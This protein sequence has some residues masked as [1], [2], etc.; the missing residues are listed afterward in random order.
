MV[1]RQQIPEMTASAETAAK[2]IINGGTLWAGGRQKDFIAEACGRAGGLM[3]IKPLDDENAVKKNDVVLYAVPET[4]RKEDIK[5]IQDWAGRGVY[6]LTFAC[7]ENELGSNIILGDLKSSAGLTV[8]DH[9]KCKMCPVDTISNVIYLW[10]WTGEFVSACSRQGKMP[11]LYL[12]YGMPG[13]VERAKKYQGKIFH[14]DF[15][16]EPIKA[17]VFAE[18]YL[19][20]IE[21]GLKA[22]RTKELKKICQAALWCRDSKAICAEGVTMGHLFPLNFEDSRAPQPIKMTAGDQNVTFQ[23]VSPAKFVLFIGY[24]CP[25]QKL[26]DQAM[27]TGFRLV[28]MSVQP[29][30][31]AEVKDRIIYIDPHWPLTDACVSVPGYDVSILPASGVMDAAIYWTMVAQMI[32]S[33]KNN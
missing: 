27:K 25:P 32:Y 7:R 10:A 14:D 1:A 13:G 3:G 22:V 31:P 28:Y 21:A 4:L 29:A 33:T 15:K 19:D 5:K 18:N 23:A 20:V 9:S 24:Q 30:K 8:T 26:V 6:V 11:I 16:I 12:S 2:L 17:G